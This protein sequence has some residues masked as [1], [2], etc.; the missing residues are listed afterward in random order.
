MSRAVPLSIALMSASMPITTICFF[1]ARVSPCSFCL[2]DRDGARSDQ[3]TFFFVS[4]RLAF[5]LLGDE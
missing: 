4:R 2:Y 3:V 5:H 1:P